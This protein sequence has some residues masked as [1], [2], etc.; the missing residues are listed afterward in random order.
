[1]N[2]LQTIQKYRFQGRSGYLIHPALGSAHTHLA[3][4]HT[5]GLDPW[6][7]EGLHV[8]HTAEEGF[9]LLA[10]RLDFAVAGCLITLLPDEFLL[11]R[12]GVPHA[13]IGGQGKIEHVGIRA[14]AVDDKQARGPLPLNLKLAHEENRLVGEEWGR[15]IPLL[16]PQHQ[17]HMFAGAG[18]E[19]YTSPHLSLGY[20]H[21]PS[22][23]V[24][25]FYLQPYQGIPQELWTYYLVFQGSQTLQVEDELTTIR[26]GELLEAPPPIQPIPH[27][28]DVPCR[29][30][31]ISVPAYRGEK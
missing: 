27:H 28:I 1:M 13:I 20:F 12:P 29:G 22:A 30:V 24:A 25:D 17:K 4:G 19:I 26:A 5:A 15:R 23:E 3:L 8:H 14:P 6:R 2:E 10:G 7:D 31:T 11:I 9:L 21:I 18:K 16:Q